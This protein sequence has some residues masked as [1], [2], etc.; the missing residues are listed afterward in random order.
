M[1]SDIMADEPEMNAAANLM[2]EITLLP[3]SATQ[4]TNFDPLLLT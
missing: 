2:I 4:I 1:P 3:I